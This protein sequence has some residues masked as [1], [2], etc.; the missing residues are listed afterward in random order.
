MGL[1]LRRRLRQNARSLRN[2][3]AGGLIRPGLL[4]IAPLLVPLAVLGLRVIMTG[5][6]TVEFRRKEFSTCSC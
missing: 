3:R 4:G 5:A 2:P 1:G 6:A